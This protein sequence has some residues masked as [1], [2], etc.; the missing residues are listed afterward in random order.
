MSA[1]KRLCGAARRIACILL[2][3]AAAVSLAGCKIEFPDDVAEATGSVSAPHTAESVAQSAAGSMGEGAGHESA[4]PDADTSRGAGVSS[5]QTASGSGNQA[6]SAS[7]PAPEQWQDSE[8][9]Q[10]KPLTCTLSIACHTVFDN[11]DQLDKEKRS[12]L[13][14][15]GV[16]YQRRTVVFYDGE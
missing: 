3:L 14:E 1:G 5:A 6:D 11:L 15:D 2:A 13:P 4:A 12:V 9:D 16:L 8:P 10:E 7:R